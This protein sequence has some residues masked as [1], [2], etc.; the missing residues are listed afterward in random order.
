MLETMLESQSLNLTGSESG[1]KG[2]ISVGL[3]RVIVLHVFWETCSWD[4][5]TLGF[6]FGQDR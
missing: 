1:P 3:R 5:G 2:L 4:L 6:L